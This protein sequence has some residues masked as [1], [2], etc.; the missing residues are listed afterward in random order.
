MTRDEE[1]TQRERKTRR[2]VA[3]VARKRTQTKIEINSATVA[4]F[5][6]K[7]G[8]GIYTIE[9]EYVAIHCTL[10]REREC[11]GRENEKSK[12]ESCWRQT[13][14]RRMRKEQRRS[15]SD[16]KGDEGKAKGKSDECRIKKE[17]RVNMSINS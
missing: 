7:Q 14:R 3:S 5:S 1:N 11:G 15:K 8:L 17:K 9:S 16:G 4:C 12:V 13:V 2:R 6:A 10:R